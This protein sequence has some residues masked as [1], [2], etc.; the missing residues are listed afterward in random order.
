MIVQG[1]HYTR[2]DLVLPAGA[3]I[4]SEQSTYKTWKRF[5]GIYAEVANELGRYYP[6]EFGYAYPIEKAHFGKKAQLV[7]APSEFITMGLFKHSVFVAMDMGFGPEFKQIKS[8]EER[9]AAQNAAIKARAYKYF[10]VTGAKMDSVEMISDRFS[11][12]R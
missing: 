12:V 2:G 4:T 8:L 1:F 7:E 5:H 3:T 10:D 11:V 9:I 6:A